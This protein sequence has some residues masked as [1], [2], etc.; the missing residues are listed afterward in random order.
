[1]FRVGSLIAALSAAY[2]AAMFRG[3]ENH[4]GYYGSTWQTLFPQAFPGDPF[5]PAGRPVMVSLYYL[6]V[7]WAG[8]IWL[9]DRFTFLVFFAMAV[10]SLAALDRTARFFGCGAFWERAALLSLVLLEHKLHIL[11]VLLVDNYGFNAT[12][13]GGVAAVWIL[14]GAL[15]GWGANRQLPLMALGMGISPKNVWLPA[16]MAAVLLW[17]DRVGRRG[18]ILSLLAAFLLGAG[19]LAFYYAQLRPADGSHAA[20]FDYMLAYMDDREANPFLYSMGWN[21]LFGAFC[22]VGLLP[23]GLPAEAARRVRWM[24]AVGLLAWL[25]GGL[26]LSCAP[27][28]LKIPHLVP[29]DVRRALRWPTYVVFVALAAALLRRFQEARSPFAVWLSGFSFLG[30]ALLHLEFRMKLAALL[31]AAALGMLLFY[32]WRRRSPSPLRL[33]AAER[34]RVLA[35]PAVLGTL[36]LYAVGAAHQRWAALDHLARHGIVGDNPTAKWTGINEYLLRETLPSATVLALSTED[37][38]RQPAPLRFDA[39]LRTRTGRRMPMGHRTA[40]YLDYAK[41]LWWEGRNRE[42]EDFVVA[43]EREDLPAVSEGLRRMGPPEL[44]V[45]PTGKSRWA[46]ISPGFGYRAETRI[47]EFTIFRSD[48]SGGPA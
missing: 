24:A 45:I 7:K 25:L 38:L 22:L 6:L 10:L 37:T 5:M 31:G 28:P 34:L 19:G 39:S 18:R 27:D 11:H 48:A 35:V 17:K 47:G 1:M 9:D 40:F 29:F 16:L 32:L 20:L 26:Y 14:Y 13:L 41:I 15:A 2:S 4:P 46:E 42:M 43:W 44:L 3:L 33:S 12:A 21:F 36:M 30:L 8:P 23:L